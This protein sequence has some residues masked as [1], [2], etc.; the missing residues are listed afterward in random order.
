MRRLIFLASI[1]LSACGGGDPDSDSRP[2]PPDA[3]ANFAQ[4]LDARG[5]DPAWTLSIRGTTLTLSQP[6]QPDLV[7]AAPGATIQ[8]HTA[9]WNATLPDGR[10]MKVSLYASSCRDPSTEVAYPFAA[11]VQLPGGALLDGCAGPTARARAGG[12]A[13]RR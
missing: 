13:A 2:A 3:A 8:A 6:N 9:A 4:P 10:A 12:R 1:A 11:E 7:G 5:A